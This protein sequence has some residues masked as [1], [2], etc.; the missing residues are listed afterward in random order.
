MAVLDYTL[1]YSIHVSNTAN[2]AV[3][4]E[5]YYLKVPRKHLKH[6]SSVFRNILQYKL[7]AGS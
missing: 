7:K 6:L 5:K 2:V 1:K 4:R 3:L